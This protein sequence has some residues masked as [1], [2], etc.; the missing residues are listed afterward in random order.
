[1]PELEMSPVATLFLELLTARLQIKLLERE[2]A[3]LKAQLGARD[4]DAV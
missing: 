2:I 1:M 4:P 3:D